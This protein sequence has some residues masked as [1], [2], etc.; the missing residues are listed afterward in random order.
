MKPEV[1]FGGR[2]VACGRP[3]R[4]SYGNDGALAVEIAEV[5]NPVRNRVTVGDVG[6]RR[7]DALPAP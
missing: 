2:Q 5:P 1:R 4:R 3:S 7:F 6:N